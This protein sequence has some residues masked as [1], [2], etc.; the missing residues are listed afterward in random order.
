M[1]ILLEFANV[2]NTS[3]GAEYQFAQIVLIRLLAQPLDAL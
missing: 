1:Y 2:K 3:E